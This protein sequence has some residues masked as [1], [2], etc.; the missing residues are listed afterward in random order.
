M[1]KHNPK[2]YKRAIEC[3]LIGYD[4]KAKAYRCYDRVSK[5]VYSTYHIRFVEHQNDDA[6]RDLNSLTPPPDHAGIPTIDAIAK[7]AKDQPYIISDDNEELAPNRN[8]ENAPQNIPADPIPPDQPEDPDVLAKPV[9]E[10]P[11][12]STWF[13]IPTAKSRPNDA[14]ETPVEHAVRESKESAD[15]I[16]KARAD[17]RHAFEQLHHNEHQEPRALQPV[18]EENIDLNQVLARLNVTKDDLGISP[19]DVDPE[20]SRTWNQAQQSI[21]AEQWK[22]AYE[23]ELKS[24]REMGVYHLIPRNK[25]PSGHR[26]HRCKGDL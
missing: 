6:I 1:G 11:R 12:Q 24:L 2:I 23:D 9:Q 18:E 3:T 10:L 4:P 13:P 25:V 22:L 21:D 17:H 8:Q 19:E 7:G 14:P 5:R 20:V 26:I 16:R 15:R